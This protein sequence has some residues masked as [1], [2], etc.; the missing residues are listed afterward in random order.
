MLKDAPFERWPVEKS[1]EDL[2]DTIIHYVFPHHGLELRCDSRNRI[3]AIFLQ[4]EQFDGFDERLLDAPLSSNRKKVIELLGP[5]SKSGGK[6]S[7]PVLGDYGPWDRF[8]RV[9][10]ALHVEYRADVDRIKMITLIRS[11]VV[12]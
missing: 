7:D 11:D 6:T 5:P 10:Y 1:I 12:P 9:D 3:S 4:S 8:E 2:E